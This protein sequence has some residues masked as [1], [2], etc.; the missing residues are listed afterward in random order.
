MKL[1]RDV[2]V[3]SCA[4]AT[5]LSTQQW[6]F[7]ILCVV[8]S[9]TALADSWSLPTPEIYSSADG[10]KRLTVYPRELSNQLDYFSDKVEGIEP[11][12]QRRAAS[13]A[14]ATAILESKA[15]GGK[16]ALMWHGPLLNN[17]SP[18][19]ALVSNSGHHV[20]T[21]DNWHEVGHG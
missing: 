2:D 14:T 13:T 21:F 4:L 7:R 5:A 16:W 6:V 9:D 20:V 11:A 8:A 1:R 17:V 10:S 18:V 3:R 19:S 12:G 15:K